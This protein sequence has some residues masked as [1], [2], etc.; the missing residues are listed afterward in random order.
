MIFGLARRLGA[1][2][3]LVSTSLLAQEK[4]A[5]RSAPDPRWAAVRRVFGQQGETEDGYFRI[6][7]P[8][9]DLHV[10]IGDVTL[11]TGFELTSYVG[12]MP[13][14]TNQLMAVGEVILREDEVPAALAEDRRKARLYY[15]DLVGNPQMPLLGFDPLRSPSSYGVKVLTIPIRNQV[16]PV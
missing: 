6:N 14:G 7:L 5:S 10:R 11:A 16:V 4:A 15:R 1:L 3:V 9:T 2:G 12:F 8:R 13:V